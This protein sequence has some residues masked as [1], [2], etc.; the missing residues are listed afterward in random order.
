[1]SDE[2]KQIRNLYRQVLQDEIDWGELKKQ[3]NQ[4]IREH[5]AP[6]PR[7]VFS[8]HVMAPALSFCLVLGFFLV[9]LP[10]K[11]EKPAAVSPAVPAVTAPEQSAQILP[12]SATE[13][14]PAE[15]EVSFLEEITE[16]K[17]AAISVS[18]LQSDVG[19]T[20]VFQRTVENVPIVV[21]WVFPGK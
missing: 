20:M 13:S 3:K 17:P 12:E 18:Q 8:H 19:T 14:L 1:M 11:T 7:F 4:F 6:A 15:P 21:I 10:E 9:M 5:F 16:Y 2:E